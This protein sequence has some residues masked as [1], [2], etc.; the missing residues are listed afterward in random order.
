MTWSTL[1]DIKLHRVICEKFRIFKCFEKNR[2][3]Q[4]HCSDPITLTINSN[5]LYVTLRAF[6]S[7]LRYVLFFGTL[8]GSIRFC[9]EECNI[10]GMVCAWLR[11]RLER[12]SNDESW[13]VVWY[14]SCFVLKNE[15]RYKRCVGCFTGVCG[16]C[17]TVGCV[18][19]GSG[20]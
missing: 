11:K 13:R 1:I 10:N 3:R 15:E 8:R 4:S 14:T 6:H 9:L 2:H 17:V 20:F 5:E 18:R 19:C 7:R 12:A 16:I